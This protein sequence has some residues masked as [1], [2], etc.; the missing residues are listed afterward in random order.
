MKIQWSNRLIILRLYL[1]QI[2]KETN[3]IVIDRYCT[4]ITQSKIRKKSKRGKML[5]FVVLCI[6]YWLVLKWHVRTTVDS[7]STE[8]R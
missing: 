2:A 7:K 1:K 3:S 6:A 5:N 4:Y 8:G